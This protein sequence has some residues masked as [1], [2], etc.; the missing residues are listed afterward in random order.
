MVLSMG[1]NRIVARNG[2]RNTINGFAGALLDWQ[3]AGSA[4]VRAFYLLPMERLPN[5]LDR[6]ALRDNEIENDRSSSDRVLWGVEMAQFPLA[7]EASW[8]LYLL[9]FEEKNRPLLPFLER[10]HYTLGG[11]AYDTSGAWQWEIEAAWQWGDSRAADLPRDSDELDHRAGLLHAEIS[12]GLALPG[13]PRLI[14]KYDYATGDSDPADGKSER[15]DT[16]FAARSRDFGLLGLFGPFFYSNINSP[17]AGVI[18]NAAPGIAVEGFY[19]PAWLAEKRDIFIGGL[20]VDRDGNSGD[21]LG[22]QFH[23]RLD[24]AVLPQRLSL[25]FGAGYLNK[26]EFLKDAPRAPDNGDTIYGVSQFTFTF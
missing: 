10:E 20:L 14:L 1:N 7:G 6:D 17:A 8:D 2:Y 13:E 21:F 25:M 15:F 22:H 5:N 23:L 19:R 11:R 3:S 24:W 12:R 16:L 9:R 18:F 26:G 4:R